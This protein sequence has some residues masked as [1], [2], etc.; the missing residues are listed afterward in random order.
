MNI[1]IVL[2]QSLLALSI[3]SYSYSE[4][5]KQLMSNSEVIASL[6]ENLNHLMRFA[7]VI[8]TKKSEQARNKCKIALKNLKT[9][10]SAVENGS[11]RINPL[12]N[13]ALNGLIWHPDPCNNPDK[14]INHIELYN[15]IRF[16]RFF[17]LISSLKYN[18]NTNN[19]DVNFKSNLKTLH[20]IE[21]S[22]AF[23]NQRFRSH[24]IPYQSAKCDTTKLSPYDAKSTICSSASNKSYNSTQSDHDHNTEY[25]TSANKTDSSNDVNLSNDTNY[26][27][28]KDVDNELRELKAMKAVSSKTASGFSDHLCKI[29]MERSGTQS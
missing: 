28:W 18:N 4:K 2:F 14:I 9:L 7:K 19:E 20:P 23:V 27:P 5:K 21:R 16:S 24:M 1:K 17:T 3:A 26:H 13:L 25:V 15:L 11:I 6:D 29:L 22:N 10:N 12:T 8:S